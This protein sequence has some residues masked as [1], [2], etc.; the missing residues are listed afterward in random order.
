LAICTKLFGDEAIQNNRCP[1]KQIDAGAGGDP[2]EVS[3]PI[4]P[5]CK[6]RNF[7]GRYL[8]PIGKR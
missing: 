8:L 7:A 5:P 3:N 4:D 6:L 1:A 2:N